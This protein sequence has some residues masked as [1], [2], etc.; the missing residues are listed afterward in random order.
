MSVRKGRIV[1]I[2]PDGIATITC[3]IDLNRAAERNA[4]DVWVDFIDNRQLSDKQRK[5]CYSLIHAIADWSGST[6]E[7]VKQAFKLDFW[8]ERVDTLADK[9][10]SLSNA[11]MSLVAEF[12]SFLVDFI[13]SNDVP[14]TFPLREYCDDIERYVYAC[15]LNKK[16]VVCG[17]RAELHHVDAIGMGND[18]NEVE[19]LGR[20]VISL[21]REHHTEIH[22]SGKDAFMQYYHLVPIVC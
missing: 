6:T 7:E 14:T 15:V 2:S 19:H 18:R 9:I 22:E 8:A 16:C 3:P 12:Q 10:F 21:C 5:C 1:S 20:E 11:P 4:R 17:K 13:I